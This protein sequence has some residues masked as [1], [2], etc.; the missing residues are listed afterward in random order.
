MSLINRI[1]AMKTTQPPT[2]ATV[3]MFPRSSSH[4]DPNMRTGIVKWFDESRGFG[5]ILQEYGEDIF[6]H[7]SDIIGKGYRTLKEGVTV[8]FVVVQ[9]PKGMQARQVVVQHQPVAIAA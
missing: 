8:S 7:Y 3:S 5:F 4:H 2:V 6:V 1:A 9:T